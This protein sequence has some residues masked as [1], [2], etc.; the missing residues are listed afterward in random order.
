M[1]LNADDSV[2]RVRAVFDSFGGEWERLRK[3]V[4]GRVSFEVH[5]RSSTST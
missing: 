3:D 2:A 4:A 5:R 1:L